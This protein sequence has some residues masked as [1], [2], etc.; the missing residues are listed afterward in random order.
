MVDNDVFEI[1]RLYPQIYL[2]CHNDHIRAASTQWRISSQDSSVLVH[3]DREAGV[4]PSALAKHLG[5]AASTPV[6]DNRAT[7]KTRLFV[8]HAG[9]K[10]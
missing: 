9:R 4:R 2:V 8:E 3:L 7:R 10:R 1:Q 5:V 6:G